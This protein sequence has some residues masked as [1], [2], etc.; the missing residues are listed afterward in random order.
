[1]LAT[2]DGESRAPVI[3]RPFLQTTNHPTAHTLPADFLVRHKGDDIRNRRIRV[4]GGEE[5]RAGQTDDIFAIIN[6]DQNNTA[7]TLQPGKPTRNG[8]DRCGI[9]ELREQRNYR[10]RITRLSGTSIRQTSVGV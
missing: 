3:A 10:R 5:N 7:F 1:M 4:Y 2:S 9:P 8:L 6:C